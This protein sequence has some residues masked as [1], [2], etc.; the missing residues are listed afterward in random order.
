VVL[1]RRQGKS[2]QAIRV[3]AGVPHRRNKLELIEMEYKREKFL[4]Q[5]RESKQYIRK[6]LGID[7]VELTTNAWSAWQ[8]DNDKDA[9]ED[10]HTNRFMPDDKDAYRIVKTID[11]REV[12]EDGTEANHD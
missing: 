6:S 12:E 8:W 1:Q 11:Q 9:F 10:F 7:R 3:N 5:H 4:I 2:G